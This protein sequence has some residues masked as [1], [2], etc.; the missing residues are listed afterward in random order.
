VLP[1]AAATGLLGPGRPVAGFLDTAGILRSVDGL[2]AAFSTAPGV[3]NTFAA[4]ACPLVAVLRLT[5]AGTG[6]EVAGPGELRPAPA[7]GFAPGRIVLDS[8]VKTEAELREALALGVAVNADSLAEVGRIARLRAAGSSSVLGP[9]VDPQVGGGAIA[10]TST[11][12]ER[13][14]RCGAA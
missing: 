6:C 12:T 3:L 9:R 10:A 8:P 5:A 13:R 14:V 2:R 1:R 7:G 4:K 11:A